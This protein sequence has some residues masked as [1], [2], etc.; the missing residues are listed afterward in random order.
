VKIKDNSARQIYFK[1]NWHSREN[2]EIIGENW[3]NIISRDMFGEL[4]H[5]NYKIIRDKLNKLQKDLIFL[6][7][8]FTEKH[9]QSDK[10]YRFIL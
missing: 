7:I 9:F 8:F 1:K 4:K 3:K 10:M 6:I 2:L 5:W